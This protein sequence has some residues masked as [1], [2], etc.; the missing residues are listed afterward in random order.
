MTDHNV[1]LPLSGLLVRMCAISSEC[2]TVL[3]TQE[4]MNAPLS[5]VVHMHTN[6]HTLL[7]SFL[8]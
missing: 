1:K 7:C 3:S 2:V 8:S 4:S 5:E 6:K